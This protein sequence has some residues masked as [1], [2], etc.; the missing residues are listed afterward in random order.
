MPERLEA[1]QMQREVG[2]MEAEK[3]YQKLVEGEHVNTQLHYQD[4]TGL[5]GYLP[6]HRP[7]ICSLPK[8]QLSII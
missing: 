7:E 4:M 8:Q 1:E 3:K 2:K 6:S 5:E